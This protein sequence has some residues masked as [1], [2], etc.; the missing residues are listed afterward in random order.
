MLHEEPH[1]RLRRFRRDDELGVLRESAQIE[2]IPE[3]ALRLRKPGP[4]TRGAA[5]LED[6]AHL[7]HEA[8]GCRREFLLRY[9]GDE[10]GGPC[11]FCD[12]CGV[13]AGGLKVSAAGGT[14]REVV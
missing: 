4:V 5:R 13:V 6:A 10:F 14:R 12:N 1:V 3:A 9:L 2:N 8:A 7:F 11:R